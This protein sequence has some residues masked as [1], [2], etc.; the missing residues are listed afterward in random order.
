[1]SDTKIRGIIDW[2]DPDFKLNPKFKEDIEKLIKNENIRKAFFEYVEE[3]ERKKQEQELKD[4][5]DDE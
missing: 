1:M 2:N 4:E 3:E 5:V